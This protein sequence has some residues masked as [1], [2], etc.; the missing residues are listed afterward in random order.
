MLTALAAFVVAPPDAQ[1]ITLIIK[2]EK[3]ASVYKMNKE[4]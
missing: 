4:S 3:H 2:H 1:H